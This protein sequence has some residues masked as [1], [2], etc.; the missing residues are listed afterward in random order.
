MHYDSDLNADSACE[1]DLNQRPL[2]KYK[3]PDNH[4]DGVERID[5]CERASPGDVAY[6]K[7][8]YH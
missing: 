8:L 4:K 3:N 6:I 1:Q 7:K 5:Y 2:V